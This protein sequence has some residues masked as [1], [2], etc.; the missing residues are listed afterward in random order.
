EPDPVGEG[1]IPGQDRVKRWRGV[2]QHT[3]PVMVNRD[4]RLSYAIDVHRH[5]RRH[6]LAVRSLIPWQVDCVHVP[7]AES[8]PD[9]EVRY[10]LELVLHAI[11]DPELQ[12]IR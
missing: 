9:P 7:R 3:P 6:G 2:E 10:K 8:V 1:A 11:P 5:V 12:T 4:S